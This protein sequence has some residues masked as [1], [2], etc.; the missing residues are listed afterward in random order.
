[1]LCLLSLVRR[2]AQQ[3][4]VPHDS[5]PGAIVSARD[6]ALSL[7]PTSKRPSAASRAIAFVFSPA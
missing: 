3:A 5:T 1:M 2:G 7:P 6:V 4:P